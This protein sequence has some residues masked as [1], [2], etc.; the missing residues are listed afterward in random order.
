[1]TKKN[2]ALSRKGIIK[3]SIGDHFSQYKWEYLILIAIIMTG[4]IVG[5]VVGFNRADNFSLSDL[6]DNVLALYINKKTSGLSVFFS[7]LFGFLGLCL[8]IICV[9]AKGYLCWI[10]FFVFLYRS[11]LIGINCAIL[12]SL[13]KFGGV[14]NVILLYFPVHLLAL[15]LLLM[16]G[17]VCLFWCFNQKNT[18]YSVLSGHFIK[19]NKSLLFLVG[20]FAS[21]LYILECV[22]MPHITSALFIGVA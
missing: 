9:N 14:V 12:I 10:S 19:E 2:G 6:P 5:F 11:F 1:M 13:Y 21:A 17:A 3:Y 8:L 15:F 7:R 16:L 22:I 18:G 4:L 20:V